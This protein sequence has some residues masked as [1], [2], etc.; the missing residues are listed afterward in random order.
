MIHSLFLHRLSLSQR[1]KTVDRDS[2]KVAIYVCID[3]FDLPPAL[4]S[5]VFICDYQS[6]T[7][8]S[9]KE[10]SREGKATTQTSK[11]VVMKLFM[12]LVEEQ[13]FIFLYD[14]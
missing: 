6:I 4:V 9:R 5:N 14:Y 11:E 10:T 1:L 3:G 12:L 7:A 13:P 8:K 2:I